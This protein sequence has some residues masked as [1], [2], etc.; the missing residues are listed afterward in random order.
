MYSG[1]TTTIVIYVLLAMTQ[2][3]KGAG[4]AL[5]SCGLHVWRWQDGDSSARKLSFQGFLYLWLKM[6]LPLEPGTRRIHLFLQALWRFA[7]HFSLYMA[8]GFEQLIAM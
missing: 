5:S 4:E 1:A 8:S 6:F 2:L 7:C 3:P